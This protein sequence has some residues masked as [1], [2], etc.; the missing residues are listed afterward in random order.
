MTNEELVEVHHNNSDLGL[1]ALAKIHGSTIPAVRKIIADSYAARGREF[2]SHLEPQDH[3]II[4]PSQLVTVEK[5][6]GYYSIISAG[7][8]IHNRSRVVPA[9]I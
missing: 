6:A 2:P 7:R 3:E 4:H 9:E 8:L 1:V 5:L